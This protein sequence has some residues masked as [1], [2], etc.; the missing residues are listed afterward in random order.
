MSGAVF[1][2]YAS[3]DAGA[4][5]RICEALRTA[6]IEVWFDIEGGLEH[7]DEWDAKI[8]GQ[9]KDCLLFVPVISANTQA[10]HEGYFRI[11]WELAAER[12]MGIA[13]GVAFIL[14][15]VIDDTREPEALV[16]DRF[17]K[18]QW[19][20]LAGG[21]V[22]PE[23]QARFLKL[24]SHR[25]GVLSHQAA[26]GSVPER[27]S[28]ARSRGKPYALIVAA[29]V[30]AG[31]GG[32]WWMRS[33]A[34]RSN[35]PA[36]PIVVTATFSAPGSNEVDQAIA[37][38]RALVSRMD[39]AQDDLAAAEQ[40]TRKASE[41]APDSA[42][43]WAEM[44]L[45]QSLYILRGWDGAEKRLSDTA[46]YANRALALDPAEMDA[47]YALALVYAS[48]GASA[49]AEAYC[50]RGLKAQPD[51]PRWYRELGGILFGEKRWDESLAVDR[52]AVKKFPNDPLSQ[53][54]LAQ[55]LRSLGDL[56]G[57]LEHVN[58]ALAL[59]PYRGAFLLKTQILGLQGNVAGA[60]ETFEQIPPEMRTE[61]RA[62]MVGMWL[63]L[64]ERRLDHVQAAAALTT[65]SYFTDNFKHL[66]GPKA[67][68]L[69]MALHVA[70][71][72]GLAHQQWQAAEEVLRQRLRDHPDD[73]EATAQLAITL[74]WMGR[75]E[76]AAREITPVEAAVREQNDDLTCPS[77]WRST[78]LRRAMSRRL[79]PIS[80]RSGTGTNGP[81]KPFGSSLGS[82]ICGA[83]RCS[84]RRCG[85]KSSRRLR[86]RSKTTGSR[87]QPP[88][89]GGGLRRRPGRAGGC[90]GRAIPSPGGRGDWSRP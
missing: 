85:K 7:G 14:P 88:R 15:I 66:N 43:V 21:V 41:L 84:S 57:S 79:S 60:R 49:Q 59:S 48:Q 67:M 10:R 40:L 24:W 62:A 54:S 32:A 11:E 29:L 33:A 70:G 34:S 27:P 5:R 36:A 75:S 42:H 8:R 47:V 13:H 9:I 69:A 18:V 22:P 31:L 39:Y 19:M 86:G 4:A 17:R 81:P 26:Q 50:R 37:R 73:L 16:P 78:M 76:E 30:A 80:D 55:V 72:D 1:L 45:M 6:G 23:A 53:Y 74:A 90:P 71:K 58:A 38:A 51:D 3:Q 52:A 68:T 2:S 44:A 87:R 77:C 56:P 65:V 25:M 83:G 82:T 61:T 35:S 20:R 28:S 12:A 64:I 63:G 46:S 89:E